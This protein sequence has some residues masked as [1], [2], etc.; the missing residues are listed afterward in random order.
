MFLLSYPVNEG[1]SDWKWVVNGGGLRSYIHRH[2]VPLML[3]VCSKE[4]VLTTAYLCTSFSQR[5]VLAKIPFRSLVNSLHFVC[6]LS[7][8]E[9]AKRIVFYSMH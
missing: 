2:L 1:L 5:G 9:W 8:E 3:H 6:I 7:S 4:D